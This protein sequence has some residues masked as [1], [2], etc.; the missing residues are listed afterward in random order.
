MAKGLEKLLLTG[1]NNIEQLFT[2]V[3]LN[4]HHFHQHWGE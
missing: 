2:K 3:E 4:I 1:E